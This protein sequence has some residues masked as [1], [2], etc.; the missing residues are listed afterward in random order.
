MG[1]TVRPL[2]V[3]ALAELNTRLL[4]K[5]EQQAVRLDE[6]ERQLHT[7]DL[8][9]MRRSQSWSLFGLSSKAV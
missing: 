4:G 5:L 1:L 8:E 3:Q 7:A 6:V 9:R 2:A